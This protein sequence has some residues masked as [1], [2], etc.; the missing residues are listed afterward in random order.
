MRGLLILTCLFFIVAGIAVH[1]GKAHPQGIPGT[2]GAAVGQPADT[3]VYKPPLR[4][5]PAG[6]SR[7]AA[8]VRGEEG[9][10]STVL[11]LAPD[12]VGLTSEKSPVLYW[13]L[14]KPE[15]GHIEFTL[16]DERK[17]QTIVRADLPSPKQGGIQAI[18]LADLKAELLP[19]VAYQWF[20]TLERDQDQPSKDVYNGGS[21]MYEPPS[22]ELN[23]KLASAGT[24]A[25]TIYAAEG[26]WYDAFSSTW[27]I[28]KAGTEKAA[29]QQRGSLLEQVG[30]GAAAPGKSKPAVDTELELLQLMRK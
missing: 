5:A 27:K 24:G 26:L 2:P 4:G 23:K 3:P 10:G 15:S 29:I 11:V 7:I 16:N 9:A 22:A 1:P 18:K 14:S 17:G 8:A 6:G 21:I 28:G 19:G 25:P 20:V 12:H 30:F 13:Y